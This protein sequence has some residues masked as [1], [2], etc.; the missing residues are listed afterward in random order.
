MRRLGLTLVLALRNVFRQRVRSLFSL[1]TI[2]VG[3]LGLFL[4]MGFNAGLMNQYRANAIR[5][6]F[7]HA[8]LTQ[9]GYRGQ[10]HARP[11]EHW[12]SDTPLMLTALRAMPG[13]RDVYPRLSFGAFVV[14]GE[15]SLIAQGEGIDG[16]AEAKF[17]DQLNYEHGGD[18]GGALDGVVL[19]S[20]LAR[21]LRVGVGDEVQV[22][23]QSATGAL[24]R[25]TARVTG[26]FHTGLPT[27]DDTSFRC[28]LE[29][30]QALVGTDRVERVAVALTRD[31]GFADFSRRV[32]AELPA[33]EAI[34]FDKL[35]EVYY[36]HGVDFLASQFGFIRAILLLVAFLGIFNVLSMSVAERT[37]EI[38]TLRAHGDSRLEVATGHL[39][40]A[41]FIGLIGALLGL[42]LAS[43]LTAS[44]LR[45]GVAMPPAPGLT[46]S[47]RIII[48]LSWA[49]AGRVLAL[50]TATA[51]A[52]CALPVW[53]ATRMSIAEA[54]RHG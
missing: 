41:G 52:G 14:R 19:G 30:A 54:L 11:W 8:E 44:A 43:A 2:G 35:D 29:V 34:P 26:V 48:E 21:G 36:Q 33:I 53:R 22:A 40:E 17:F 32:A 6:R 28:P 25:R 18:F 3:A 46:R 50:C 12:L 31:D 10:A 39:L 13:V 7:G 1:G 4:F 16:V 9:R 49:D 15:T 27:L 20:G 37:A 45:H 51:M 42:A 5:A 23:V 47:F 24:A 38:G